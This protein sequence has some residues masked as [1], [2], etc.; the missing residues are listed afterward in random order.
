MVCPVTHTLQGALV[1]QV[2]PNMVKNTEDTHPHNIFQV[3]CE[4]SLRAAEFHLKNTPFYSD[5]LK[6][7][8][9]SS[10]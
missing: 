4:K 8:V 9:L 1:G 5:N 10:Q 3:T 2:S 6:P 7:V